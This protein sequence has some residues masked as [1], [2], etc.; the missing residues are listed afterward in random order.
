MFQLA[1]YK[2]DIRCDSS[3]TLSYW[4]NGYY[5][6]VSGHLVWGVMCLLLTAVPGMVWGMGMFIN[7]MTMCS[8]LSGLVWA[9]LGWII[10]PLKI[11][12]G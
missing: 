12:R 11:L 10:V 7:D 6:L 1:L 4:L 9:L 2:D 3:T 5:L 8:F